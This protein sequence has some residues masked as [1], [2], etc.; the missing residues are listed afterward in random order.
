MEAALGSPSMP[1]LKP[2]R[3]FRKLSD[4]TVTKQIVFSAWSAVPTAVA[5]LMSYEAT[6]RA[7]GVLTVLKQNDPESRKAVG[8]RLQYRLSDDRASAMS[9]LALF[10]P[11]PGLA[12]RADELRVAR[13]RGDVISAREFARK[14]GSARV[15]SNRQPWNGYFAMPGLLPTALRGKSDEELAQSFRVPSA[16][17]PDDEDIGGSTTN[18]IAHIAEARSFVDH[19]ADDSRPVDSVTAKLAAFSP[20][21]IAFRALSAL[22]LDSE[23]GEEDR[24]VEAA[25]MAEGFR[26]L[27]NRPETVALLSQLYDD[28]SAYW[29]KVLTYCA[30]ETSAR[31]WTSTCSSCTEISAANRSTGPTC[32]Q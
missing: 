26:T 31:C 27:F 28:G 4:R 32:R 24:W 7:A 10:W 20:A 8:Q 25:R 12:M 5:S 19:E 3:H 9:T 29:R 6:R 16:T 22:P 18:L 11:H 17:T 15:R 13:D 21:N 1:Y 14:F 23:I 2:G 30:E